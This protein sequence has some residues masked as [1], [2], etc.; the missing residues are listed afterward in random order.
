MSGTK[1]TE[2][3]ALLN[4]GVI[5]RVFKNVKFLVSATAIQR[6]MLD[7]VE[8]L[9]DRGAG[10]CD[11][12][13]FSAENDYLSISLTRIVC[14]D[15]SVTIVGSYTQKDNFISV[16]NYTP[17]T[18]TLTDVMPLG[19]KDK[20]WFKIKDLFFTVSELTTTVGSFGYFELNDLNSYNN[21]GDDLGDVSS[22]QIQGGKVGDSTAISVEDGEISLATFDNDPQATSYLPFSPKDL[23]VDGLDIKIYNDAAHPNS[24]SSV[25]ASIGT[26][27]FKID[28]F[29]F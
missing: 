12:D 4:D 1:Y 24:S 3:S 11:V 18:L 15:T 25:G 16:G 10:G 13:T 14:N 8:S 9:W 2:K 23:T 5:A 21:V 20:K 19:Y 6:A 17:S 29:L 28:G 26:V 27:N 22:F 7:M